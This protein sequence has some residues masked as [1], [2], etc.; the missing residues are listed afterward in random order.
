MKN[1]RGF[2]LI[3]LLVVIAI[4]GILASVVLSSLSTARIKGRDARRLSDMHQLQI[5]LEMYYSQYGV[6]PVGNAGSDRSE[7]INS[8]GYGALN[9]LGALIDNS[10]I[11]KLPYDPGTNGYKGPSG[12]GG[13]QFYSYWSDGTNYLLG[14]VQEMKDHSGCTQ[15]GNW[16]GPADANYTY[17]YYIR[18]GV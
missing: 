1:S 4:I 10:M 8:N 14:A 5:A 12:C 18:V 7:W 15:I 6:Y 11:P 3:E 2:T 13:A 16:N 17:Q 9:P